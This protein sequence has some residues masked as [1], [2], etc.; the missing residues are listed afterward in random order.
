MGRE[1]A[2]KTAKNPNDVIVLDW[3][4]HGNT[5]ATMEL[6]PYKWCQKPTLNTTIHN[7]EVKVDN[8]KETKCEGYI[9]PS[10]VHVV[11]MPDVYRGKYSRANGYSDL[12][13]AEMYAAEVGAIVVEDESNNA[14]TCSN[15]SEPL[16]RSPDGRAKLG[17]GGCGIFIAESAMGCG[18]QVNHYFCCLLFIT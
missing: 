10:H 7:S 16:R 11:N 14:R 15:P 2:K 1:H 4:Y 8:D 18:G 9:Q 3:G 17:I 6:S 12:E 5:S 13:A